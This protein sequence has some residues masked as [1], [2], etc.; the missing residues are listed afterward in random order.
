[1]VFTTSNFKVALLEIR[2][3]Y[4]VDAFERVIDTAKLTF[5][6][7]TPCTAVY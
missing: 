2:Y 4:S 1:M 6:G 7:K 3:S 5:R